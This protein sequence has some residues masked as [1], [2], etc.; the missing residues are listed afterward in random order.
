MHTCV[1]RPATSAPIPVRAG[2][3][4]GAALSVVRRVAA[5]LHFVAHP[6]LE[7]NDRRMKEAAFVFSAILM[8]GNRRLLAERM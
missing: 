6:P 3:F 5:G 2:L 1:R 7:D 4:F 8:L